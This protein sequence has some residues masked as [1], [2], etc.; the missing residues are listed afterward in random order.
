VPVILI[1]GMREYQICQVVQ[2]DTLTRIARELGSSVDKIVAANR[3]SNP[4]LI[5][6]GQILRVPLGN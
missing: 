1:P 2:G 4:Y 5:R 3:I 6:V